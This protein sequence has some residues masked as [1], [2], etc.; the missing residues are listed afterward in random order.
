M[1]DKFKRH[2]QCGPGGMKCRCC[3]PQAGD[4]K[5]E[6]RAARARLKAEAKKEEAEAS[7]EE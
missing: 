6:R 1:A 5:A 2:Q 4:R 3:G 7:K